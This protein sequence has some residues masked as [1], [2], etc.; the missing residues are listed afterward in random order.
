MVC[1]PVTSLVMQLEWLGSG[2]GGSSRRLRR[3]L[4]LAW[5][6]KQAKKRARG[7]AGLL[8]AALPARP[9]RRTFLVPVGRG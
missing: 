9:V 3:R 1:C 5:L 2:G 4:K 8:W 7:L 6:P